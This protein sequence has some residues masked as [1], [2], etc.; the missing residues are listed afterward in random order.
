MCIRDRTY[1]YPTVSYEIADQLTKRL[2]TE[3]RVTVPGHTQ[4]GGSPCPYDRVPVSYTH[5]DVYKRQA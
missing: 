4:R 1:K 5:L 2:G 3:V